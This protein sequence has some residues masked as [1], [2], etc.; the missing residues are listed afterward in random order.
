MIGI[1]D[2]GVGGLTVLREIKKAIPNE[3]LL[4]FGDTARV[5][6]G[7]KSE[8]TIQS[9]SEEIVKFLVSQGAK[10]IVIACNTA[11]SFATKHLRKKFPK[12]VFHDVISPC[13]KKALNGKEGN[14]LIVG[15]KATVSSE[16][17][18]KSLQNNFF[19]GR[20]YSQACPLFVPF[21]EEGLQNDSLLFEVAKR[22]LEK[23]KKKRIDYVILGCTHYPLMKKTISK[24]FNREVEM[25][26][27]AREVAKEV[28]RNKTKNGSKRKIA[29]EFYFSDWSKHSETLV[30]S[31][32]GYEP[33]IK[34]HKIN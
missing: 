5:P 16:A 28:A 26:N 15:T 31:I 3:K 19:P 21:I 10:E 25:I 33:R 7:S 30:K 34:I 23:F 12:I 29:D 17:Y 27:A 14:V 24:V 13:V 11:S 8:K 4:Y 32:I 22:Y 20:I 9:Y 18:K 2:S 1:F 6:W